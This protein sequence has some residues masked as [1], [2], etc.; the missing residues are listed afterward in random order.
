LLQNVVNDVV[1]EILSRQGDTF[2]FDAITSEKYNYGSGKSLE[3]SGN[4]FLLFCGQSVIG[5]Q[6]TQVYLENVFS[7]KRGGL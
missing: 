2:N 1:R 5:I 6:L 3:N 7:N 4:S